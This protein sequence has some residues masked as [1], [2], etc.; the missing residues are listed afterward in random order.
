MGIEANIILEATLDTPS[1]WGAWVGCGYGEGESR[2]AAILSAKSA[3][4]EL[5][6]KMMPNRYHAL[7]RPKDEITLKARMEWD[8]WRSIQTFWRNDK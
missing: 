1:L 8:S 6:G 3:D 7:N 4:D 2:A 5:E